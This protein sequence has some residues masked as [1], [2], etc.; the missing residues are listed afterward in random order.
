MEACLRG[1]GGGG[2]SRAG[3]LLAS[4]AAF[5]R[6]TFAGSE[7]GSYGGGSRLEAGVPADV[8][9]VAGLLIIS[10]AELAKLDWDCLEED[11]GTDT[12]SGSSV[13]EKG[14]A[15]RLG[16]STLDMS[17]PTAGGVMPTRAD[18]PCASHHFW[19]SELAGGS[20]GS[21][22][23]Y[24][25]RSSSSELSSSSKDVLSPISAFRFL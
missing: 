21:M 14:F 7:E 16:L 6:P 3:V 24:P 11:R 10:Y 15:G 4:F 18:W 12:Q 23:S 8:D 25:I 20:P 1:R 13:S 9:I 17:L 19:R 2:V 5:A 22:A